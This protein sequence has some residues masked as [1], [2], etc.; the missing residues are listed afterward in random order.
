MQSDKSGG[1]SARLTRRQ[2]VATGA[3]GGAVLAVGRTPGGQGN[4]D[5]LTEE[6]ARTLAAICDRIV[7]ADDFPSATQAGVLTYIDKQL[8]RHYRRHRDA[9]RDGLA[10][11]NAMSR[12]RFGKDLAAL[13][14]HLH[15]LE[16]SRLCSVQRSPRFDHA[17]MQ[18]DA[19]LDRSRVRSAGTTESHAH[20]SHP[21][22]GGA[23]TDH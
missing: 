1:K 4:W 7:P 15:S 8:A 12:K 9:Y 2:F 5:S 14:T 18:T 21:P 3:L 19:P 22:D 6:Q 16:G 20:L 13:P 23:K 11:A 10:Q 17:T